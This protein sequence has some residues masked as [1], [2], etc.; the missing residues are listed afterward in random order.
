MLTIRDLIEQFEIQGE[1]QVSAY[2]HE[3]DK[4]IILAEGYE[5]KF[6]KNN[7]KYLNAEII[8]M[9]AENSVLIIEITT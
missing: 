4:R 8:Y 6:L 5:I 9:Y 2:D 7:E 3:N 1:Y